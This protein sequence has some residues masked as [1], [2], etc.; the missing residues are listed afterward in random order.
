M[1]DYKFRGKRVDDGVWT[2]GFLFK[3]W[4]KAYILWGITNGI[5]NM[6]EVISQTVGQLSELSAIKNKNIYEGDI[7]RVTNPNGETDNLCVVE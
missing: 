1:R 7:L 6:V 2:Y 4:E 3:S 5:P